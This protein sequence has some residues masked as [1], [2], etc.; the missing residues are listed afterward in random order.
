MDIYN[1]L[2]VLSQCGLLI[3]MLLHIYFSI[4]QLFISTFSNSCIYFQMFISHK[5]NIFRINA[6]VLSNLFYCC[7]DIA[8]CFP[9]HNVET[10]FDLHQLSIA[11]GNLL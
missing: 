7:I 4:F 3:K 6:F 5:C 9:V 11:S 2:L 1:K 8:F 10:I